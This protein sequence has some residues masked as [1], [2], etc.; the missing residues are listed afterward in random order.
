MIGRNGGFEDSRVPEGPWRQWWQS[1]RLHLEGAG[2]SV[3]T[4]ENY[5]YAL[6]LAAESVGDTPPTKVTTGHM[7]R[8]MARLN[9]AKSA[10]TALTRYRALGSFFSWLVAEGEIERS[11][12]DRVPAPRVQDKP[13]D[14]LQLADVAKILRACEGKTFNDRRDA[15]LVRWLFDTGC[16]GG[17]IVAMKISDVDLMAGKAIVTGKGNKARVVAFGRKAA[18]DL[19]RYIRARSLHRHASS[20][21]LWLGERGPLQGPWAVTDILKRRAVQG[22]VDQRVFGHLGRHSFAHLW[23]SE[24]GNEGDLMRLAG[25]TSPMMLRRYGASAAT[26]RAIAAHR[27][28]SPGDRV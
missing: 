11:P 19:D 14:V 1:F 2:R 18:R 5:G 9:D 7:Q 8:F 20:P 3:H 10:K 4:I 26:E 27:E 23:L 15:A 13:P 25:W 21:M 17:E 22:G 12:L 6:M 28:R 24:G 16:R